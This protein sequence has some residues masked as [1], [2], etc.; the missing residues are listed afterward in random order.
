MAFFNV[1]SNPSD[2]CCCVAWKYWICG[3]DAVLVRNRLA[4]Q[5]PENREGSIAYRVQ[6]RPVR[7]D[8]VDVSPSEVF[9]CAVEIEVVWCGNVFPTSEFV[10]SSVSYRKRRRAVLMLYFLKFFIEY[11]SCV[12]QVYINKLCK[13][14]TLIRKCVRCFFLYAFS[15]CCSFC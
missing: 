13:V 10:F 9:S 1:Q 2:D 15:V 4:F 5:T 7:A 12:K 8:A 3:H 11:W 14:H 6:W